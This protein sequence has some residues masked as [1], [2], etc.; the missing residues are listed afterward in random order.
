MTVL[1]AI[2]QGFRRTLAAPRLVLGLWLVNALFAL[3]AAYLMS[4]VLEDGIGPSLFHQTLEKGFDSDW[5]ADFKID[6]EGLAASFSPAVIG[7]GAVYENLED[8]WSGRLFT[9]FPSLVALGLGYALLWAFLLGGI[10]DA[11]ARPAL[12]RPDAAPP[13]R[14]ATL[15][16]FLAACGRTFGRYLQLAL[17]AAVVYYLIYRLARFLFGWLEEATR[18]VTQE[19]TVFA[20]VLL[21]AVLVVLLLHLVRMVFDYAKIAAFEGGEGV[22]ALGALG[23]GLLFVAASPL[24][25][26]GVY[27]GVGLVSLALVVAWTQIAPGAHDSSLAALLFGLFLAQLYLATRLAL[28]VSQLAAQLAFFQARQ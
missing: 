16:N 9:R 23:Q 21:I 14:R 11:V 3:P 25:V 19:R 26:V 1:N 8:W 5:L 13:A 10:L 22:S 2:I 27:G 24:R 20:G 6:A 17:A 7:A 28:R 18:E 4:G 12:A 15:A